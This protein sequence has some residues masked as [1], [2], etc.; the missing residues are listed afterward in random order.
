MKKNICLHK[1]REILGKV[2]GFAF[3][4]GTFELNLELVQTN[5]INNLLNNGKR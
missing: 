5:Q 2:F 4:K 1:V 3:L